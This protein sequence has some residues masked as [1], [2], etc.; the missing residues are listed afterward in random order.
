MGSSLNHRRVFTQVG[1]KLNRALE[2]TESVE[3]AADL[4]RIRGLPEQTIAYPEPVL[5]VRQVPL[6]ARWRTSW[7]AR[8][9][10]LGGRMRGA[11]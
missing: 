10:R 11:R 6:R 3:K 9:C 7:C 4:R 5:V 8:S 2:F 1:L